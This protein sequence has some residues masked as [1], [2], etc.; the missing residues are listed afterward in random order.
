MDEI[1]VGVMKENIKAINF[2]KKHGMN[3][4]CYLLGMDF[5]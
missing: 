2:Y 1:E 3:E 4:E 5:E